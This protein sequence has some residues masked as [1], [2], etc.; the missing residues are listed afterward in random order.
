MYKFKKFT[1]ILDA[2]ESLDNVVIR[3]SS[4]SVL[5]VTI[6]GITTSTIVPEDMITKHHKCPAYTNIG[7]CWKGR[8][9]WDKS[10]PVVAYV[11]HGNKMNK[12]IAS[13]A[14]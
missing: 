4:D 12:V 10:V 1:S 6:K 11:A 8:A 9:G 14:Q 3:K 7:K 13:S 5:G 2:M